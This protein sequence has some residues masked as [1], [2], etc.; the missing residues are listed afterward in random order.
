M[1][2]ARQG[3]DANLRIISV[4]YLILV[5]AAT[6]VMC[7][8]TRGGLLV[9]VV[10]VVG[11]IQSNTIAVH[12]QS[13]RSASAAAVGTRSRCIFHVLARDCSFCQGEQVANIRLALHPTVDVTDNGPFCAEQPPGTKRQS[14]ASVHVRRGSCRNGRICCVYGATPIFVIFPAQ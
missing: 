8:P 2:C 12:L 5:V 10:I 13:G 9:P 1:H 3:S 7:R 4:G 11:E 6:G 14:T